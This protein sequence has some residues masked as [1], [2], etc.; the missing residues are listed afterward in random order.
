VPLIAQNTMLGV[1]HLRSKT[2]SLYHKR[3]AWIYQL[4]TTIAE[5]IALALAN[6]HLRD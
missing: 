5:H 4:T 6:L 3:Q 1:F 2:T